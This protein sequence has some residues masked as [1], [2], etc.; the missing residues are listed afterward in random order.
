MDDSLLLWLV[1]CLVRASCMKLYAL[2]NTLGFVYS[3]TTNGG[4]RLTGPQQT[5]DSSLIIL[6]LICSYD[7]H[8]NSNYCD[9]ISF[10]VLVL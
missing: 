10:L 8:S 5:T 6:Y 9:F 3:P 4:T 7:K 2:E 1:Y